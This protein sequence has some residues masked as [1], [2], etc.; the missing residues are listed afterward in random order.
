MEKVKHSARYKRI[1]DETYADARRRYEREWYQRNWG[2]RLSSYTQMK[3]RSVKSE[4]L[5]EHTIL[6][7]LGF[8][9][10]IHL[11]ITNRYS[12]F[13]FYAEKNNE[14]YFIEVTTGFSKYIVS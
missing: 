6:P 8:T 14:K 7:K 12:P 1:G 9:N 3:E 11:S 2:V 13:D 4:N 5:A 10:I